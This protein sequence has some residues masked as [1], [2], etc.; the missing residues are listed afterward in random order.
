MV[1]FVD[2]KLVGDLHHLSNCD[3]TSLVK[4]I[5]NFEW[6]DALV[7]QFL[8]LRENGAGEDDNTCGAIA[9]FVVL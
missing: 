6:V 8:C 7:Q 1:L 2:V 4:S 5:R 9:D 3:F